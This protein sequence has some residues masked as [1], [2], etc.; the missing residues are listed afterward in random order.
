MDGNCCIHTLALES[1]EKSV[2]TAEREFWRVESV[3]ADSPYRCET[4]RCCQKC[5]NADVLEEMSFREE[6]EQ[7]QIESSVELDV[8]N[9]KLVA[10][11][12][13]IEN[14]SIALKPNRF[15]AESVLRSQLA[16]FKKK[17][18]MREDTV[19]SHDK[20]V[21]RGYVKADHQLTAAECTA[22]ASTPG[23]G[24]FIPW[25]IVHNEG[26]IS[27]PC[28]IVFDAS[29]KTPGGNS[30][31]GILA[32][33]KNRLVKI[34][35]LLARFRQRSAA[36]TADI[37]MAYNGTWLQPGHI[38]FQKYLW[39]QG[40]EEKMPTTVMYVLTLIY[41]VKPSGGQC[42]VSIEK[43]A[44]HFKMQG[45]YVDAASVLEEDVYVDDIIS[46]QDSV[47]DCYEVATGIREVLAAGSLSVKAFTFSG[48]KPEEAVSADGLHVGVAGYL[49]RPEDD[50]LLLDIGPPRLGKAKRGKMPEPVVGD[51]GSALRKCFTRRTLAGV[52]ARVVD[53]LGLATPASS[54]TSMTYAP[55]SLI[56]M[57]LCPWSY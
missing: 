20:L 15:V 30:L 35:N 26:S 45:L 39:K 57:T 34:Q 51:F 33:G 12:P 17:P 32:K 7:A 18:E 21:T 4:C 49:W 14:P 27:T 52:T 5:K 55:G 24:Y 38:K 2:K 23:D 40:L 11:L 48:Q 31:N 10:S 1:R 6:A 25:R 37:S 13:F 44:A 9:K 42:Q 47:Q 46:S 3:G 29:S 43:L 16:L 53:P 28:R 8:L 56:G 36:V 50:L 41:G 19:K 54:W 22:I